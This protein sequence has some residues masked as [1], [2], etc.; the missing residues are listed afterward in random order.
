[1]YT[2]SDI[3][4]VEFT[5]NMG[6]FKIAEVEVFVDRCAET[7]ESLTQEKEELS[8]KLSILAD[9]LQEYRRDEDS[10]RSALVSAQRLGDSI[11]RDAHTKADEILAK[12]HEEADSI[13]GEAK[14]SIG[15]YESELERL[16]KEIA[17]FRARVLTLYKDHLAIIK[18]IPDLSAYT[19]PPKPSA[20]PV[21]E[22]KAK[23]PEKPPVTAS[24]Q[25]APSTKYANLK[26][27]D[28]Y[29]IESD[30]D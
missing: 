26:F 7:V 8:K 2:A 13:V 24:T 25:P 29:D 20:E 9:K 21:P 14:N 1:M 15:M 22:E 4:S 17:D 6:G 5:K 11:V 28:D 18:S 30:N 23:E 10:I 16:K 3:R 19:A 27:G 12:A